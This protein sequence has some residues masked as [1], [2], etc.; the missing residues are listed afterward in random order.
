MAG[1]RI[2]EGDHWC[3]TTIRN[4]GMGFMGYF[5]P[6]SSNEFTDSPLLFQNF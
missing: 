6:V 4:K 5:K 3:V 2:G 1:G